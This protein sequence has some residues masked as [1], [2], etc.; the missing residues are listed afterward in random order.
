M[1]AQSR[2]AP[3]AGRTIMRDVIVVG[4]GGSGLAA[5]IEAASL[6]RSVAV[7]EKGERLGGTT[8][9][10]IGSI[11]ASNTPHQ[12]R[13]GILDSPDD[14]LADLYRFN[15]K[16]NLPNHEVFSRLLVDNVPDTIRWLMDMGITF[17]GPLKELPHRKP[18]MHNVLPNSRAYIFHMA[19]RARRLG[20]DLHTA[21]AARELIRED[22]R[23][24]GVVADG[25]NGPIS[26]RARGGVVLASGDYSS[27]SE[28]KAELINA[29]VASFPGVNPT[30]TGDGHR[31]ATAIGARIVNGH[32]Y[33]A[34]IRFP[35]PPP[36]WITNLPPH[37]P[38]T[39]AM[40]A[41][42][43]HLPGWLLRPLLMA[44]LT[45]VLVP[46]PK[47][48][49]EGGIL[50]NRRGERFAD[51]LGD[52][53]GPLASQ[54]EQQ[55]FILLDAHHIDKFTGWPWYVST[56]P[57]FAY[58]AIADYRRNRKD[59]VFEGATLADLAAKMGVDGAV[60]EQTVANYNAMEPA[61]GPPRGNRRGLGP[62]PFIAM[63]PVWTRVNFIDG[64]LAVDDS[65]RVLGEDQQPISGLYAAG[66]TGLGGVLL[67]GHGH[68]LGWVFTS[69]R[70]A[71]RHAAHCVVTEDLEQSAT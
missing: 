49:Q 25:P 13:A 8:G 18:R 54:P 2:Q 60:L 40:N 51:E 16:L 3:S 5:G 41:A 14:H 1:S 43:T 38:F 53:D 58:A 46:S 22:G 61:G 9:R 71:G 6:N 59:M 17:Y 23:V 28:M 31:M 64:G 12:Y 57:G 47:L 45:T 66:L 68:H 56:V 37:R 30:N 27:D 52:I 32:L 11:S 50:V 67:E 48:F 55:G 15:A 7:L 44:F 63:G 69:G 65:F 24:V 35:E 42:L 36:K 70:F 4:G 26:F 62:G 29:S 20:V 21:T 19:R 39:W 33:H 10:S 34:G